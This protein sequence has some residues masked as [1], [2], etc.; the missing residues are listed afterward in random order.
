MQPQCWDKG[1]ERN[2]AGVQKGQENMQPGPNLHKGPDRR[3]SRSH[4][5]CW[6][7]CSPRGH[8]ADVSGSA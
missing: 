7:R 3:L 8:A 2:P 5:Q 1:D 6:W 4:E